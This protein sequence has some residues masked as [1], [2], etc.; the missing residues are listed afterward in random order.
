MNMY[1]YLRTW[2][3]LWDTPH[4]GSQVFKH[5]LDY[6]KDLAWEDW[7]FLFLFSLN[8]FLILLHVK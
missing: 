3:T 6:G 7:L 4:A 8:L 5:T 2:K 1:K